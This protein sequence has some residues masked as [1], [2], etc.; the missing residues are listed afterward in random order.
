MIFQKT[1]NKF[2]KFWGL[3][4]VAFLV[5]IGSLLAVSLISPEA[6]EAFGIWSVAALGVLAGSNAAITIGTSPSRDRATP[7]S[8]LKG[9]PVEQL[10]PE[11]E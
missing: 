1:W 7:T 6:A 3:K 4:G 8:I 10:P 2:A 11:D 5:V 9:Q